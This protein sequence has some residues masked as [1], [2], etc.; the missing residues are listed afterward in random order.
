MPNIFE[1]A[2][3]LKHYSVRTEETYKHWLRQYW[4]FLRGRKRAEG[5]AQLAAAAK[6]K[7]FL[8]YLA[9]E[10]HVAAATQNQALNCG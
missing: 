5:F 3:R 7:A 10:R 2:L 4:K 6:V 9:V 1:G 8:E